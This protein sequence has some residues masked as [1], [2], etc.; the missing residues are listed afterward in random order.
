MAS[1]FWG[2]VVNAVLPGAPYNRHTQTYNPAA[3][4]TSIISGA[5]G[6]ANPLA[7]QLTNMFMSRNPQVQGHY[8]GMRGW[9][10][11]LAD[12]K[13]NQKAMQGY[14]PGMSVPNVGMQGF[15][16]QGVNMGQVA[17]SV[18]MSGLAGLM[19][20]QD[21]ALNNRLASNEQR[22]ADSLSARMTAMPAQVGPS[23]QG[24]A[25]GA[26]G[27]GWTGEAAQGIAQG[28]SDQARFNSS[29]A[30]FGDSMGRWS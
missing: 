12:F 13:S 9:D 7:G 23:G 11:M 17:P 6:N 29:A 21:A 28:L 4:R 18:P 26:F 19:T 8:A 14:Q 20:Q 25:R 30:S 3:L 24:G 16:P 15:V 10:G 1:R 2:G 5:V 27:G 22:I